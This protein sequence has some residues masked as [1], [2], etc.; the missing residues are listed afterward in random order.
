MEIHANDMVLLQT[1]VLVYLCLVSLQ[2]NAKNIFIQNGMYRGSVLS[3]AI[4]W[5]RD[6][7]PARSDN[8]Q[9]G[10]LCNCTNF[11]IGYQK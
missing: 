5:T 9:H 1:N 6:S 2:K 11:Y 3:V 8:A 7:L 4:C 10:R